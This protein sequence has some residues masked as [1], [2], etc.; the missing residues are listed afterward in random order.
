MKPIIL[1]PLSLSMLGLQI[2][3]SWQAF[4][5][6]PTGKALGPW[7]SLFLPVF[8]IELVV[9]RFDKHGSKYRL[10]IRKLKVNHTCSASRYRSCMTGPS[11]C[12]FCFRSLWSESHLVHRCNHNVSRRHFAMGSGIG[13]SLHWC[14]SNQL[15]P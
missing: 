12:A 7:S 15:A 8:T 14:Q 2:L 13:A 10:F 1:L 4:F 11:R 9:N 6:Y 5:N 3:P